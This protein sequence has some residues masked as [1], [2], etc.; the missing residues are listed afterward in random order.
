MSS[1]EGEVRG[2]ACV[3]ERKSRRR[4]GER[5]AGRRE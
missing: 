2:E 4:K 3:S 1:V 5:R